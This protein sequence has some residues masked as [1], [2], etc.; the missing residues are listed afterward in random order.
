MK[1]VN[2]SRHSIR[3]LL[4]LTSSLA[5]I[6]SFSVASADEPIDYVK[7]I[8]PI[9]RERCYACH[10][11]LKHEGN[12]RLDTAALSIK[13]GD[14]G[15]AIQPNHVET[16][17]LLKRVIATEEAER[18]PPPEEGGP[19]TET[20]IN[21]LQ[22]WIASGAYAPTDEQ[23]EADPKQHWSFQ[24]IQRPAV[25]K[26]EAS[27]GR[28][29]IDAFLHQ[30]HLKHELT[31]QPEAERIILLRRLHLDLIGIPPT[32]DE[33]SACETDTSPEWYE[34]TVNRLLDDP[35]HGER[36][37][38]HWMDIWRYS[39]WWGL[40]D[41]LRNSQKHLWHYRD[42]IVES[43]NE[44]LPYDEMVRL[45]LAADELH[46]AD[47]KKLRAT[48]Y[49]A[50]NFNLFNR[51]QWMEETVEHVSKGFLGLTMNCARCHD[52]KYDPLEQDDF[53]R[54]RAFFEPYQVRMEAVPGELDLTRDG[55][56][57]VFDGLL[58]EPTYLYIRGDERNPDK[59][60]AIEPGV[61]AILRFDD[62][63]VQTVSLP[64]EAW[65]PERRSWVVDAYLA[66]ARK[67][68][69]TAE[70]ELMNAN[71]KMLAAAKVEEQFRIE[72]TEGKG[73][74]ATEKP[75]V[76]DPS[77]KTFIISDS[78]KTLDTSR[79]KL[80]AGEWEHQP[81]RLEQ[82]KDG[83]TRSTLRLL[84]KPPRDFDATIRFITLGGSQWRSV[85]L[86]FDAT[87]DDPTQPAA[88][89]DSEQFVYVSAATSGSK[90]QAAYQQAGAWQYPSGSAVRSIPVKLNQEYTLRVQVRDSLLNAFLNDELLIAWNT[91]IA[92]RD[93]ALQIITFD[94]IAVLHEVTLRKL[95]PAIVLRQP[96]GA[97]AGQPDTLE[98]AVAAVVDAKSESKIREA[99]LA[100]AQA[101]LESVERRAEALQAELNTADITQ[102][103]KKHAA[104][105]A[106]RM[107]AVAKARLDVASA[108]Q[109]LLRATDDKKQVFETNSKKAQKSL[110]KAIKAGEAEIK[111]SDQFAKFSGAAWT[112]TRF[113]NSGSD[114]PSIEFPAT[115]TGRRSA[116]AH[117]ITDRRNPL[118]ARVAVNHLWTR[119]MGEPLV[120]TVFDFGRNG[121]PPQHPELLDWLASEL[122]D[123]GWSMKHVH[124]LIVSSA[125]Y[126]M[127]SST[128]DAEIASKKDPENHYWWRRVPIRIESHLVRDSLL[129]LAGTLDSKMGGP[130]IPSDQQETSL[131]RSLYFYHSNNERNLFLTTFDEALV[132]DC[133]R[134]EQSIVPQQALA[135]SN[136]HLALD[137]AEKIALRLADKSADDASFVRAAFR[138][139][140]GINP[141]PDEITAS[142][143]AI[144]TW[145]SLPGG[146]AKSAQANFVWVLINHND[147]VTLR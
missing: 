108:E 76:A 110:E 147:F 19:L 57:R 120:P 38:R 14:S 63:K 137:A 117:W 78:F 65:Q 105:R 54:M 106:E 136:S 82:K 32:L 98:T 112:P 3:M 50:R 55:I 15:A 133:Y 45:M 23:P 73:S 114:D 62:L 70:A 30:Q 48:G 56:P 124:R 41:Q 69:T 53:Y 11:A 8:K 140:T 47:L 88:N 139:V 119:H 83:A 58:E 145:K 59:S 6:L 37:A 2:D 86:S 89:S 24:L 135:L 94:A 1:L 141:S 122:I 126:R 20:Q 109:A 79:W 18:M 123:S 107:V 67:R 49:L 28:N 17:L 35:R 127:T 40:G 95:D 142:E 91:P 87:Q 60:K 115:S 46:P 138:L 111:P 92:R 74:V 12:L 85:G 52:H 25:P 51:A 101:E 39:D 116:L 75:A 16:S 134:R 44:D 71:E 93:G 132:K 146:N 10:G 118:T 9:L 33:I 36:W 104:I 121:T 22:R 43:L 29:P 144:K 72:E 125:A 102:Q 90:I 128:A 113:R 31:P 68:V 64:A 61:P 103:D 26:N 21:L 130:S 80:F 34:N 7:Q 96:S 131:R 84:D 81:G 42:W 66:A 27:W 99:A 77:E 100:V 143:S 5:A 129:S 13:G 4:L 97:A